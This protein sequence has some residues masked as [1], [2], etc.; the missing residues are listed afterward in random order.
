MRLEYVE[1]HPKSERWDGI[2][3]PEMPSIEAQCVCVVRV[4][5]SHHELVAAGTATGQ[6]DVVREAI[7]L[8]ESGAKVRA[9]QERE[10]DG[11]EY[12]LGPVS[13]FTPTHNE[14]AGSFEC[15][16]WRVRGRICLAGDAGRFFNRMGRVGGFRP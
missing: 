5:I 11:G 15:W 4:L 2:T 14:A 9:D 8:L 1:A 13:N 10:R 7:Q 12:A 3:P 16:L 6:R